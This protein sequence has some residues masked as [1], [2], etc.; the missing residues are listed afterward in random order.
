M[1]YNIG[2]V[3]SSYLVNFVTNLDPNGPGLQ[4]WPKASNAEE[5]MLFG[6][7]VYE[8]NYPIASQPHIQFFKRYFALQP[9]F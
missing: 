5:T 2:N 1:D 4:N 3:L 9:A 6:N 7:G 8:A